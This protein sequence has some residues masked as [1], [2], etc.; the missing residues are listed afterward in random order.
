MTEELWL[1]AG[2]IVL[3]FVHIIAQ[4][5]GLNIQ[6]GA[7]FNV[8]ARDEQKPP[9]TGIPGRLSRALR[10]FLETFPLFAAAILIAHVANTHNALTLWG[11]HLYFWGR[12]VYLPLYALGIPYVRSL[13]WTVATAG[14]AMV[15]AGLI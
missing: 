9:L 15:L 12:V 4:A 14:I 2:A 13:V 3:G 5:T 1:L 8:S 7:D 10:N 6:Q 11:A